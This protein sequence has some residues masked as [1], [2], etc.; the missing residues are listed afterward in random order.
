MK[1]AFGTVGLGIL[2]WRGHRSLA[3][4]LKT[5][6]KQ[7]FFSL[8]DECLIFLPDPNEEV[9]TVANQYPLRIETAPVNQGILVGM[10]VISDRLDTDYIFF[11]EN[12]CPLLESQ[13]EARRQI[14]K[15]GEILASGTACMARMR[16]VNKSGEPFHGIDKYYRYFP[17]PDTLQ[18]QLR[19]IFRPQKAKKLCGTAI[20]AEA[21]PA[22]KFPNYIRNIGDGFYMVDTAVMPWTNL[23]IIIKRSFFRKTILPYCTSVPFTRGAN[24]FRNIEVELNQSEFWRKSGW[25]IAC[26]PGLL[27]HKRID[28]RGY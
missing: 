18:A 20:Y 8:F 1:Y 21:N 28:D 7:D 9:V 4:A 17:N 22:A 11:T 26:G 6:Q 19:R 13:S 14:R 2:S 27:T 10:K 12:D 24:G 3:A 23:S 5:Y 16:H 15:A 25:K